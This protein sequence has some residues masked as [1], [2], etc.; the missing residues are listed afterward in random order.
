ME[1]IS[2]ISVSEENKID[3]VVS[4]LYRRVHKNIE[5]KLISQLKILG[6]K[7]GG[8]KGRLKKVI[9]SNDLRALASYM[10]DNTVILGVRI[11]DNGMAIE[12]DIP[13]LK[14]TPEDEE[15]VFNSDDPKT[16]WS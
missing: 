12:F 9:Y 6:V 7:K 16:E 3:D 4:N 14:D 5:E 10:Y 2:D 11:S 1:K 13:N 15:L 8:V